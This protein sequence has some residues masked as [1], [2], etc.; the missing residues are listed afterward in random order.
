M[1]A[2][3]WEVK[4]IL[5]TFLISFGGLSTILQAMAF[6]KDITG[7]GFMLL[8]KTT[9]AILSCAVCSLILLI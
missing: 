6:V 1:L 4:T 9:H 7:F 5:S 2:T 8:Q 3:P